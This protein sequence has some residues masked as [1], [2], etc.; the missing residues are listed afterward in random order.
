M[1]IDYD[2]DGIKICKELKKPTR[3]PPQFSPVQADDRP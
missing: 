3:I 1:M 2:P